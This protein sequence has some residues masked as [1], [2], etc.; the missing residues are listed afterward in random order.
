MKQAEDIHEKAETRDRFD[1][2][3][4]QKRVDTIHHRRSYQTARVAYA[5]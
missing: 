5:N 3:N 2:N 1:G 4:K